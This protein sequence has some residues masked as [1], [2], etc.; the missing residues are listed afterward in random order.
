[1]SQAISKKETTQTAV[2]FLINLYYTEYDILL[3]SEDYE[4]AKQMEK[5]QIIDA[6]YEGMQANTFDPN[7]GR[8]L[9]Y[10]SETYNK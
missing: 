7:K 8:A 4:Q 1:M 6:F 2:D 9:I 5:E 3:P 10:Y